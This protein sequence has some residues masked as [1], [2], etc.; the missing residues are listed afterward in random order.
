MHPVAASGPAGAGNLERPPLLA[1][2]YFPPGFRSVASLYY[3]QPILITLANE[4]NVSYGE[5][6]NIP[7]I[8]QA[9]YAVGLVTICPMGDLVRRRPLVLLCVA[10]AA[11]LSLILALVPNLRA[12]QAI[13][14][15]SG[16]RP[17]SGHGVV[18]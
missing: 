7:T 18:C 3:P 6:T 17:I 2:C 5:T 11:V 16:K 15:S 9:A 8:L 4:L 13:N 10:S 1:D 14:V 12:F